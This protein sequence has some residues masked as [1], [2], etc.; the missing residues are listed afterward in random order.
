MRAIIEA[1]NFSAAT[2]P[3]DFSNARIPGPEILPAGGG[4][5]CNGPEDLV[6]NARMRD[7]QHGVSW[8]KPCNGAD[9]THHPHTE[10]P[11]CLAARPAKPVVVLQE[12]VLPAIGKVRLHPFERKPLDDAAVDFPQRV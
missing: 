1:F 12:V 5:A 8:M 7:N 3:P 2:S 11:V 6:Y 9:G 4:L 10:A